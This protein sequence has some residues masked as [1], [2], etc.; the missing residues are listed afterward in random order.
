MQ[1][2]NSKIKD[3]VY[4]NPQVLACDFELGLVNSLQTKFE[5]SSVCGCLFNLGQTI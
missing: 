5:G 2:R 3:L 4:F 1:F